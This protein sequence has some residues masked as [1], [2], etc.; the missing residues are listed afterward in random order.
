MDKR[1]IIYVYGPKRLSEKYLSD[2]PLVKE[3]G[4]WLKIGQ[5]EDSGK[6]DWREHTLRERALKRIKQISKTGIPE[7]C[8]LFDVFEYPISP[9]NKTDNEI[10]N[11]LTRDIYNLE[12]SKEN[13]KMVDDS[14]I[15]AGQEFVYGVTRSQVLNAIA[16]FEHDLLI[17]FYS[18]ESK[19]GEFDTLMQMIIENQ[20]GSP[21]EVDGDIGDDEN[22]QDVEGPAVT[23]DDGKFCDSLWRDVIDKIKSKIK[24]KILCYP[25]RSYICFKSS[26]DGYG[27]NIEYSKRNETVSCGIYTL[28]GTE[29]LNELNGYIRDKNIKES[30]VDLNLTQG[31]RNKNKWRWCLFDTTNKPYQE[32]VDWISQ[33]SINLYLAFEP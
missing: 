24:G 25:G 8:L 7:T 11:I 2:K 9:D 14:E 15:K 12:S 3:E 31:K 21:Y 10:R 13:N 22:H 26:R 19:K 33:N 28:I 23:G 20:D 27:Y 16:K 32:L 18:D 29:K 17:E 4:G 1:T 30:L 6:L 5:T